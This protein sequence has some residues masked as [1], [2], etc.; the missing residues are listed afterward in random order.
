[1]T[2]RRISHSRAF[3]IVAMALACA[4]S[5]APVSA[6]SAVSS[7]HAGAESTAVVG[8]AESDYVISESGIGPIRLGMTLEQARGA[9]R[10]AT[11]ERSS[12]GEGA[13]LVA[14]A[15]APGATITLWAD[16]ENADAAIDWSKKIENIETFSPAFHTSAGIHPG[17]LVT[18]VERAY[19]KTKAIM[20]S[21]I[22]SRQYITFEAQPAWVRFR[23]DYTGIFEGDSRTTTA[24]S[25]GAKIHSIAIE[26][27]SVPE[28][29]VP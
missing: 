21:E 1:M 11:F 18:D 20:L 28:R 27:P 29:S 8:R 16:E 9:A 3:I 17:S 26:T 22:E 7:V 2:A 6:E 15:L 23:L 4:P 13:P 19:G 24:Y 25:P 12:D 5:D 10:T 14:V